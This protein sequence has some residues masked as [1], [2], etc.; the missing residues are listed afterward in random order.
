MRTRDRAGVEPGL[1]RGAGPRPRHHHGLQPD[2]DGAVGE[3]R[4]GAASVAAADGSA[5]A[6]DARAARVRPVEPTACTRSR[7][8]CSSWA[9]RTSP[10]LGIWE[11]A[12]PHL[13]A[14]VAQTG[15]S[16]SMSQLDGSDIVYVARVPVPKIIA[17]VGAHRH[18][19][20]GRGDLDGPGTARRARRRR[21]DARAG[22]AVAVG[23]HPAGLADPPPSSSAI[24]AACA[25]G[26]GR[27]PTSGC[28]SASGRSPRRSVTRRGRPWP[29]STS[30]C[31]PP[32]RR[33]PTSSAATCRCCSTTAAD[34]TDEWSNLARLP[35][36]DPLIRG[37]SHG[38]RHRAHAATSPSCWAAM[39]SA[40]AAGSL[41]NGEW[42]VSSS[43]AA[44]ATSPARAGPP[45]ARRGRR[46]TRRRSSARDVQAGSAS[47]SS[48]T[49]LRHRP[50]GGP[51]AKSASA[52]AVTIEE[53][54]RAAGSSRRHA[55]RRPSRHAR[56]EVGEAPVGGVGRR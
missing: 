32:R 21:A 3:R 29:R 34:I 51:A 42:S 25:S 41:K 49:A 17:L 11:L 28:P 38:G 2:G 23:D 7:P 1:R 8:R 31:T 35:V 53:V 40:R 37:V 5:A 56:L 14:L 12:R 44:P 18:A 10:P 45:G 19:V 24:S 15:E 52:G 4:R 20:S 46:R 47:G 6:D 50:R 48:G 30:P 26:A 22:D 43:T 55:H 39:K 13:E 36:P 16:S 9:R 33:S 54:P 27:C